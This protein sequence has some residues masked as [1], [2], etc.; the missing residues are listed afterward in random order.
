MDL[1]EATHVF[2]GEGARHPWE[3]ARLDVARKLIARHVALAPGSIVIDIGCGDAFVT[4]SLAAEFPD[5]RFYGVDSGFTSQWLAGAPPRHPNLSLL[6]NLDEAPHGARAAALILL[7][8]VIEH[9]ADDRAFLDQ[10]RE[11]GLVDAQTRLL[12]TVPAYQ[13]L[14]TAHDEFLHHYRRYSNRSLRARLEQ[15]GFQVDEIGY[16]FFSLLPARLM[17]LGRERL[18][19]RRAVTGTGLNN[20]GH[21]AGASWLTHLLRADAG[22]GFALRKAGISLPGLSNFAVCRK[23]A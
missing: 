12:V 22:L 7:M 16:F 13:W 4:A 9:V 18:F 20:P 23:S 3:R 5:A 8:D 21:A 6:R 19:G 11:R 14:F 17:Q 1:V 2:S 15:S 10:L